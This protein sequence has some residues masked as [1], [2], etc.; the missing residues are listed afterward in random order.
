MS[1]TIIKTQFGIFIVIYYLCTFSPCASFEKRLGDAIIDTSQASKQ[2]TNVLPLAASLPL[3]ASPP[4]AVS[5]PAAIVPHPLRHSAHNPYLL[6]SAKHTHKNYKHYRKHNSNK[7]MEHWK[8]LKDGKDN[9]FKSRRKDNINSNWKSTTED[10]QY[11]DVHPNTVNRVKDIKESVKFNDPQGSAVSFRTI[12]ENNIN[13]ERNRRSWLRNSYDKNVTVWP[14]RKAVEI[15]GDITVGGLMMVHE[16]EDYRVCGPI[17]PQGGIQALETMLYTLDHINEKMKD[18][19][20]GIR[21]GAL[22]LD[23]CDKDT[24]GLEQAVDFIKGEYSLLIF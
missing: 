4:L 7:S 21:L 22:V 10:F 9:T 6:H 16:R 8:Y 23:D 13:A 19:I 14:Q 15:E 11:L 18:F 12:L 2:H 17:M 20:P 24:Y 5:P 3:T 1:G